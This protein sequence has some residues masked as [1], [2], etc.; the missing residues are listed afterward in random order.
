MIP[1]SG[2]RFSDQIMLRQEAAGSDLQSV[3]GGP[4]AQIRLDHQPRADAELGP[5]DLHVLQHALH[6]IARLRKR[7]ALDPV[8]RIDIGV[9]RISAA[10]PPR[11]DRTARRR[12]L[13]QA[14]FQI[15][16]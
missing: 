14:F 8:D 1:K 16:L 7:N 6:V 10:A 15:M 4:A 2:H 11:T 12:R 3:R 13:R 9:A 5:I